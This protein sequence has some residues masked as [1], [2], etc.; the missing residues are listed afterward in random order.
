[1]KPILR[2]LLGIALVL[3]G[4]L[5]AAFFGLLLLIAD[6]TTRCQ[7]NHEQLVPI[8]LVVLGL[9]LTVVGV[10]L[11]IGRLGGRTTSPRRA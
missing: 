11:L 2:I 4:I 8:G 10:F 9:A 1:M 5:T 3:V 6:C 7:T